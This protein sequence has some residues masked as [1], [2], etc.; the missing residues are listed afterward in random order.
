MFFTM[1]FFITPA[2]LLIFALFALYQQEKFYDKKFD[3][4]I[5]QLKH[6]KSS[7][8]KEIINN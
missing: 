3:F 2:L 8:N 1:V 7:E 6:C 4:L 5:D